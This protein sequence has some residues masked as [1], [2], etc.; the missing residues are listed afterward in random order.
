MKNWIPTK[1]HIIFGT[2]FTTVV[3]VVY[4]FSVW[5]VNMSINKL[6]DIYKTNNSLSSNDQTYRFILSVSESQ[7]EYIEKLR[8]FFIHNDGDIDFI[9]NIESVGSKSGVSFNIQSINN[10]KNP[11]E[12]LVIVKAEGTWLE[13][14]NFLNMLDRM[15]YGI[16]IKS[17]SL[18]SHLKNVWNA[19]V[20]FIAYKDLKNI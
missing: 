17:L 19:S 12:I 8:S 16:N 7:K 10:T 1:K 6:A 13:V 18:E 2:L 14:N 15:P 3:L 9:K 4:I 5:F 20:D 11:K